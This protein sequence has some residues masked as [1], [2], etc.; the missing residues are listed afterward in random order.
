[1][2]EFLKIVA[3]SH[4]VTLS[5]NDHSVSTL[6]VWSIIVQNIQNEK[7]MKYKRYQI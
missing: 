2:F 3:Q 7:R 6:R 4:R 1:M 5:V